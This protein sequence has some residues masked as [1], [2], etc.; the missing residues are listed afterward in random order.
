[1]ELLTTGLTANLEQVKLEAVERLGL[2]Q[3][4]LEDLED[5]EAQA[6][7]QIPR[8]FRNR[9]QLLMKTS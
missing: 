4:N 1:M 3:V 8:K 7:N 6:I 2:E 5:L 9:K